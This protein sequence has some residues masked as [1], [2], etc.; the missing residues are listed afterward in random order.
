MVEFND[1][2]TVD[3]RGQL[4]VEKTDQGYSVV[5]DGILMNF[6]NEEDAKAYL[7]DIEAKNIFCYW[8]MFRSP[9]IRKR[10]KDAEKKENNTNNVK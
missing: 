2:K 6:N 7:Y 4:R 8:K 9:K 3:L 1:G 10:V 5:G